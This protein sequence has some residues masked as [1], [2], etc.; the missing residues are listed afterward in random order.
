MF[1]HNKSI[2]A[3]S[4]T[5]SSEQNVVNNELQDEADDTFDEGGNPIQ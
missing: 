3:L 1:N 4:A 2:E 5:E